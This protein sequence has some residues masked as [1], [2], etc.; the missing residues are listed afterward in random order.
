MHMHYIY[1]NRSHVTRGN[2]KNGIDTDPMTTMQQWSLAEK[3]KVNG[4]NE[5]LSLTAE[6]E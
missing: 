3:P 4:A 1:L 5:A 2:R 6:M